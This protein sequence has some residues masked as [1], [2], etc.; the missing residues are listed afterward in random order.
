MFNVYFLFGQKL[1]VGLELLYFLFIN[2]LSGI[3]CQHK[4]QMQVSFC[5]RT[6]DN[7]C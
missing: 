4:Q 2:T 3:I 5:E 7:D 1:T 6:K